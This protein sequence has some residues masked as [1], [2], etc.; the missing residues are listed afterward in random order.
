MDRLPL[1]HPG[2]R[3]IGRNRHP[4][5]QRPIARNAIHRR[6][7]GRRFERRR[8]DWHRR[9]GKLPPR[10]PSPSSRA[11]PK[12]TDSGNHDRRHFQYFVGKPSQLAHCS[13]LHPRR[14][15][16]RSFLHRKDWS[17]PRSHRQ[18]WCIGYH[19]IRPRRNCL[20]TQPPRIGCTLQP[21]LHQ[22]PAHIPRR[23]YLIYI[24]RQDYRRSAFLLGKASGENKNV[25][26]FDP[27]PL[28]V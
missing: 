22:L 15:T 27:R 18:E 23:T 13:H 24:R 5:I 20:D 10:S 21:C 11:T 14:D 19:P 8:Q 16:S 9:M 1:F 17:H 26:G 28:H 4:V 6:M 12:R 7:V 2:R 3:A 25:L